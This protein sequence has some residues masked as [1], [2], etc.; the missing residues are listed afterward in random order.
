MN[1][2][3]KA[4]AFDLDGL[5]VNT[6]DI[7]DQVCDEL[8]GRRGLKFS[9]ELKL[10]M[11]GRPGAVAIQ[12][13][14]TELMLSDGIEILQAEVETIFHRIMPNHVQTLPG[15]PELLEFARAERIP[16]C[17]ATSSFR[18][19][20]DRVLEECDLVSH[21]DFILTSEDVVEGKPHPE[22]Y[23]KAAARHGVDPADLLVLEDSVNGSLA[24]VSAGTVTVAVPGRHSVGCDYSHVDHVAEN[25]HDPLIFRLL[26][27]SLDF[28]N[29]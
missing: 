4:I 16:A 17:V 13:M 28:L 3:I 29:R 10:K 15:L 25:L 18:K 2:K 9:Q 21:F 7:Y 23:L 24:G 20:A 19:H 11:M 14:K 22:I 8:L 6:E 27:D 1:K 26:N 12:I 5:M